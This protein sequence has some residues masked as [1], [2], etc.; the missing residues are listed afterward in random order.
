VISNVILHLNNDL[1]ILADLEELPGPGDRN[2]RC[3]NVRGVDGKRP[4][5]VHDRDSIFVFPMAMVRLI[6]APAGS[7]AHQSKPRP[8]KA[9]VAE[10][11]VTESPSA[12]APSDPLDQYDAPDPDELPALPA[13]ADSTPPPIEEEEP[14]EDLLARIR[15]A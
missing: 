12:E 6:E 5:F 11:A 13:P 10:A 14:D 7:G 15:S 4:S 1:P 3:T 8:Q 9:A 2:V